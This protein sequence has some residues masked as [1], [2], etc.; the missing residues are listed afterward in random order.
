MLL[1]EKNRLTIFTA[2]AAVL[3]LYSCGL[4]SESPEEKAQRDS[5]ARVA[6][7]QRIDSLKRKNPLLIV[8]PDSNY[9][10]TYIDKYQNGIV[11]FRG[12]FRQGQRHGQWMSFYPNGEA[13]SEM[14]YDKGKREGPNVAYF[15]NGK[16]RYTGNYRN[17]QRD[18]IWVFYDSTGVV[19]ERAVYEN[20]R[21]KKKLGPETKK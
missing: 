16:V 4:G 7:K 6:E 11:K 18:S 9:T 2:I 5:V 20:D 1:K 14:H 10:G 17:D 15:E 8:P 3:L 19:A 12:F 21:I 13:W